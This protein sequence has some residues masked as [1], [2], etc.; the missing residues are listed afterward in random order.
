MLCPN[1]KHNLSW[2]L[3]GFVY[4][5]NNITNFP[6]YT[7]VDALRN[8]EEYK[9]L[10]ND[11]DNDCR[12]QYCK[13]CWD[14][15]SLGQVSK[16]QTD[17]QFHRIYSKINP[18]Y[19]KVDGAIGNTC[20]SQ[21]T[22]CG[23]ESS[24][25]WQKLVPRFLP[26][27]NKELWD[28]VEQAKSN[29]VQLDFGGGEPWLNEVER[30]QNLLQNLVD[31]DYAKNIKLRY[32]TNASVY[33]RKLISYFKKFRQVEITFSIDDIEERFE[34]NRWPLKWNVV[35]RNISRLKKLQQQYPNIVL[36][37]NYTVSCWTFHRTE[38]F[39]QWANDIG[40]NSVN[41]NI[42]VIPDVF[43]IYSLP[44][45]LSSATPFDNLVGTAPIEN[46]Q[47]KFLYENSVIDE[48]RGTNWKAVFP[49]LLELVE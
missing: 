45:K 44:K 46:W 31:L 18:E 22:I 7:S 12:S 15:E 30:Q 23:P 5:C 43:S 24:T 8:S 3:P 41:F 17:L 29:L 16:R 49:E 28:V 27:Q 39:T 48:F 25:M 21:C 9:N 37:I 1:V 38:L 33:P 2:K 11:N 32:N 13:R 26:I 36:T 20:N 10:V 42:L 35:L 47:Q 40:L 4:P 6:Q 19:L 34:Y 14:K